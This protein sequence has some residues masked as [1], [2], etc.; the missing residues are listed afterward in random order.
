MHSSVGVGGSVQEITRQL[1]YTGITRIIPTVRVR[2]QGRA[3][4][5]AGEGLA[6]P[7]FVAPTARARMQLPDGWLPD[8]QSC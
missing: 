4:S 6:T 3:D 2:A 5:R 7:M 8:G 1:A